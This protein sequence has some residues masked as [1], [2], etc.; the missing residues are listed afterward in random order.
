MGLGEMGLGEM[1]G[2]HCFNG[3][4]QGKPHLV[5]CPLIRKSPDTPRHPEGPEI[6][7]L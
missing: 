7:L 5:G 6:K 4:F 3:R 1:G 2:H